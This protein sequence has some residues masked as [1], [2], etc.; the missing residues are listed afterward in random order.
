MRT[1]TSRIVE[2]QQRELELRRGYFLHHGQ[3]LPNWPIIQ[4]LDDFPQPVVSELQDF[5]AAL[6]KFSIGMRNHRM[7]ADR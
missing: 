5:D 4:L 2:V 6:P 1:A 3:Y 7:V